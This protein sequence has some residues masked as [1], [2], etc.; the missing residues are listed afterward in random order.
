MSS[1]I[2]EIKNQNSNYETV[3]FSFL[4]CATLHGPREQN[5]VK[6]ET[7]VNI[8]K[9]QF[10]RNRPRAAAPPGGVSRRDVLAALLAGTVAAGVWTS[11]SAAAALKAAG[12][13]A[14]NPGLTAT[15]MAT[16]KAAADVIVPA[17]DTPGAGEA[18]VPQFV[19]ALVTH[20][21][22]PEEASFFRTG[23]SE[24]DASAQAR[25]HMAFAACSP[26]QGAALM[27][28]L[29]SASPYGG[30]TFSLTDRMLD[31][32]APFYLRLRD[33]VVYGYFTSEA[34]S[35][36]ELRYLPVPGRFEANVD[37][38]TWPFQTVI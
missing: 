20:W 29:R 23:L 8:S 33:L 31:P 1:N 9:L 17:T 37:M 6:T 25:Y 34:G 36:K 26:E 14:S 30:R 13:T 16:L 35:N 22:R 21:M 27:Q 24:L 3:L 15:E 12:A 11:A 5:D 18:G 28:A 4:P 19:A 7:R 32:K 2:E 10:A 38:K